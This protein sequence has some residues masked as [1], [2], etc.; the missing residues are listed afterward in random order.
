MR[1]WTVLPD[2]VSVNLHEADADAVVALMQARGIGVEAGIWTRAD[3]MR[4]VA[5]RLPRYSLRVL[6]EMGDAP[7]AA[8]EAEAIL[9]TLRTAG[10]ALPILLT[11]RAP[12]SGRWSRWR[13]PAASPPASASRTARNF[14][15]GRSPRATPPSSPP[16]RA[17]S[18]DAPATIYL[19]LTHLLSSTFLTH[20]FIC[21]TMRPRPD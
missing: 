13:P 14:P 17:S 10:V 16:P 21:T 19:S 15:A 3:A 8:S 2:Y 18:D 12:P 4:F 1:G 5:S 20:L 6:V 9:A 7:T 11:A